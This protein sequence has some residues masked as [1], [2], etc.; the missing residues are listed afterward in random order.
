M[1]IFSDKRGQIGGMT[2]GLNKFVSFI[3]GIAVLFFIAAAIVP[4]A[5]TGGD[6]LG[7]AT[8]CSTAG[9]FFNTSQSLC[10]NGTGVADTGLVTFDAFPL[11]TLFA[12]G[13]IVF[14]IVAVFLL[15]AA[16]KGPG[17]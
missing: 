2:A 4:V 13:G 1:D 5:Q 16:M 10:L 9:G 3:V 17:K 11:A 6:E 15:N 8:T 7:D 12:G 14:I